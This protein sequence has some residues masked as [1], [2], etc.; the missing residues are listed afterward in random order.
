[1]IV[2]LHHPPYQSQQRYRYV[3]SDLFEAL[4][5]FTTDP[6][7]WYKIRTSPLE[8]MVSPVLHD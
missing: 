8:G 1:M 5:W 6:G 7:H 3:L 2:I 4:Q